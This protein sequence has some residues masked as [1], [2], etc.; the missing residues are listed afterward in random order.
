VLYDEDS[1]GE[2]PFDSAQS[3]PPAQIPSSR[4]SAALSQYFCGYQD[5]KRR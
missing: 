5:K 4:L 3:F 2:S 1:E